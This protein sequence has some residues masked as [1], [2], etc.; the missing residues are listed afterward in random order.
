MI[1]TLRRASYFA[2]P[3][4]RAEHRAPRP[5]RPLRIVPAALRQAAGELLQPRPQ[6]VLRVLEALYAS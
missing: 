4:L 1:Q 5:L 3:P 2:H 6:S